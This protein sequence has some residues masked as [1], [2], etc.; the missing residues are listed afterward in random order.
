MGTLKDID[1][2]FLILWGIILLKKKQE[3]L[4]CPQ[5]RIIQSWL[6]KFRLLYKAQAVC[7]PIFPSGLD[8]W[9]IICGFCSSL[10]ET[11][12]SGIRYN[13][14]KL[15][16]P[17]S[18]TVPATAQSANCACFSEVGLHQSHQWQAFHKATLLIR[19]SVST[20]FTSLATFS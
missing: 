19:E 13:F 17:L 11:L 7:W 8:E 6:E 18:P 1:V 9:T 2:I 3:K 4:L 20:S 14:D 15:E 16:V 5:G 10:F 12:F